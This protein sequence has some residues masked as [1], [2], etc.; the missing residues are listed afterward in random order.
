MLSIPVSTPWE[1]NLMPAFAKDAE[2][3]AAA[4][5]RLPVALSAGLM[6]TALALS[7][8]AGSLASYFMGRRTSR[9]KPVDILRTL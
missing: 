6:G 7:L 2:T 9:M 5:V 4:A 3:T 1:I 8:F